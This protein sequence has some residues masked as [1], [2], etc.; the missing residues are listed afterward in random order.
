MPDYPKTDLNTVRRLAKRGVYDEA[1]VHAI[2]DEALICHAGFVH[3]GR[4]FVMPTIHVRTGRTVYLHGAPANR[5][6]SVIA[7]GVPVCLT[8]TLI[9][10][11]VFARSVFH[12]SM[13]YRSAML[14]GTGRAVTDPEEKWKA[15]EALT[16]H[17]AKGR[18]N[19]ARVP[20]EVETKTTAVVAVEI[21]SA[22]AKVRTGGANDEEEDYALP[23]W[24]GVLPLSLTP[25]TPEPD[26]RMENGTSV[27]EYVRRYTRTK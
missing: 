8:M 5:M 3:D 18:W 16:E 14:F 10:G 2:V 15:F 7:S 9:D 27:P 12:H 1:T 13:N 20:N 24:A 11:I 25:G 4:P 23:V 22:S 19:D 21:E 6:L 26:P 17:I